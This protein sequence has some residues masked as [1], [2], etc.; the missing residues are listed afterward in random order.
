M[1]NKL[2]AFDSNFQVQIMITVF[3]GESI[4]CLFFQIPNWLEYRISPIEVTS[5]LDSTKNFTGAYFAYQV[6]TYLAH[7]VEILAS[8]PNLLSF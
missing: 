5:R 4:V 8:K 6:I 3:A 1:K 7:V 2:G